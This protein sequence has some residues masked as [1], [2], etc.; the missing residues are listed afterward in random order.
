MNAEHEVRKNRVIVGAAPLVRRQIAQR[1][2]AGTAGPTATKLDAAV[3]RAQG[4]QA[5]VGLGW[6]PAIADAAVA[7][8]LAALGPMAP[9]EQLIFEALRRCQ[10]PS[11]V[12]MARPA[13]A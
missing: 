4:K 6:K 13:R 7:D 2:G 3:L 8:A 10:R 11:N 5:L 9:L 12:V 1:Q